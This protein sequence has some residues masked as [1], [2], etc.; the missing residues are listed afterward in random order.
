M[1]HILMLR[2][3]HMLHEMYDTFILELQE[4]EWENVIHDRFNFPNLD[5]LFL[6]LGTIVQYI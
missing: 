2:W 5:I 1:W 4:W 6:M 3:V